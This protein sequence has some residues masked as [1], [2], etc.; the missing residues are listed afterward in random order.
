MYLIFQILPKI[1]STKAISF[2]RLDTND[3][4]SMYF[5]NLWCLRYLKYSDFIWSLMTAEKYNNQNRLREFEFIKIFENAGFNT[6]YIE[7]KVSKKD[8]DKLSKIKLLKKYSKI[9]KKELAITQSKIISTRKNVSNSI[10]HHSNDW[11]Y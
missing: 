4:N 2:H 10:H 9:P 7:S 1:T 8:I 3:F 11:I 6:L 5:D